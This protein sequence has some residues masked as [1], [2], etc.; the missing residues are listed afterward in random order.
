MS[1]IPCRDGGAPSNRDPGDLR[2]AQIDG[3]AFLTAPSGERCRSFGGHGIEY[4][5]PTGQIIIAKR[6]ECVLHGAPASPVGKQ[7]QAEPDFKHGDGARPNIVRRLAVEPTH[8]LAGRMALHQLRQYIGIEKNHR[9][10]FAGLA[11]WPRISGKGSSKP[12]FAKRAA[13]A[14]PS[15]PWRGASRATAARKISRASSSM[16]LPCRAARCCRRR[17]TSSSRLRTRI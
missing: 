8:D 11:L 17:F 3:A 13:M 2:I 16:L 5:N 12:I 9:P 10:S 1:D 14:D 15:R 4:R 7:L 6:S